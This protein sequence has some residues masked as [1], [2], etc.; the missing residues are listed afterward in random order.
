MLAKNVLRN[1]PPQI[2]GFAGTLTILDLSFN[3][4]T[5]LPDDV[6]GLHQLAVLNVRNNHL[7]QLPATLYHLAHLEE[8]RD[9]PLFFFFLGGGGNSKELYGS[10]P[11]TQY[12]RD[13]ALR[14]CPL[15]PV[16][17]CLCQFVC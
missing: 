7:S 3:K 12:G 6:A 9:Q 13:E 17:S 5:Q 16:V 1:V 15:E 14:Q 8:V 10:T 4:L 2:F 11:P